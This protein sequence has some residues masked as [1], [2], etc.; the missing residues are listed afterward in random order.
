[1]LGHFK[2]SRVRRN[3]ILSSHLHLRALCTEVNKRKSKSISTRYKPSCAL[4]ILYVRFTYLFIVVF[5]CRKSYNSG[6]YVLRDPSIVLVKWLLV[7]VR[8]R[9]DP[10][11]F[12]KSLY[13]QVKTTR[14]ILTTC[15]LHLGKSIDIC[16]VIWSRYWLLRGGSNEYLGKQEFFDNTLK[17]STGQEYSRTNLPSILL[18]YFTFFFTLTYIYCISIMHPGQS[19]RAWPTAPSHT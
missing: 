14:S 8:G 9:S 2:S 19:A 6:V 18:M 13:Y 12:A 4:T 7:L 3:C 1:M 10:R 11:W 16:K 15:H 5:A 17:E